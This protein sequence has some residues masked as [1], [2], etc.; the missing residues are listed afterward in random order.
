MYP[1]SRLGD[2]VDFGELQNQKTYP[3][4][5]NGCSFFHSTGFEIA[6]RGI[7]GQPDSAYD[8]FERVM[9]HGYARN[10]LWAAALKW[11]TGQLISE[12][13]NNALLI[14]WGFQCA[15]ASEFAGRSRV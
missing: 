1:V 7:A 8:A 15:A 5:E 4:Y 10:R 6:A 11:D 2:L 14:L 13:L 9:K 3:N 12:P